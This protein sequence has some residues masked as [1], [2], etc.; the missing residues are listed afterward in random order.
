MRA[1]LKSQLSF[2]HAL[3][4]TILFRRGYWT[5]IADLPKDFHISFKYTMDESGSVAPKPGGTFDVKS[6]KT[7]EELGLANRK[8]DEGIN[9]VKREYYSLTVF[10]HAGHACQLDAEA[11]FK[12]SAE[13][14]FAILTNPD[15]SLVFRDVYSCT[16]RY[17]C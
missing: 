2:T 15:N 3:G 13:T 4:C 11:K 7:L 9:R 14:M 6:C 5:A 1:S 8:V 12:M 10:N 17:G 16:Y